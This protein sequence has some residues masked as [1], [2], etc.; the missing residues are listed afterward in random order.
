MCNSLRWIS[1]RSSRMRSER[2]A[3]RDDRLARPVD[4][5]AVVVG[6]CLGQADLHGQR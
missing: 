3:E 6:L 4:F 1:P 5:Q 2:A